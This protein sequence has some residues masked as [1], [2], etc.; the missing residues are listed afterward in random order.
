MSR[1][2]IKKK[3]D[4]AVTTVLLKYHLPKTQ[5]QIRLKCAPHKSFNFLF[6][7]L[8]AVCIQIYLL[9]FFRIYSG[10]VMRHFKHSLINY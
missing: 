5:L 7:T 6:D 9:P 4:K 2:N 8:I 1:T 10:C 3:N